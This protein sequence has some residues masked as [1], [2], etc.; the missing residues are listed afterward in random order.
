MLKKL[1]N[2]VK[3]SLIKILF[4][5]KQESQKQTLNEV[6]IENGVIKIGSNSDVKALTIA[7]HNYNDSEANVIIG[8]N[9][10]LLCQIELQSKDAQVVIGDRVYIG[11]GTRIFCREKVEIQS[12]VLISWGCT[13]LD[14]NFHSL[15]SV[16][17]KDDVINGKRGWTHL[18]W[19]GVAHKS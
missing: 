12:D 7:S 13:I 2:A 5:S 9:C 3:K 19:T 10:Q 8:S 4:D 6:L 18:T 11:P 14:T 15:K 1:K 16:D 17:R